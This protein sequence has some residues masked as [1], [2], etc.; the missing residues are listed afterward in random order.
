MARKS[1]KTCYSSKRAQP[2]PTKTVAALLARVEQIG[3]AAAP[4]SAGLD[5]LAKQRAALE[6]LLIE[7]TAAGENVPRSA[8]KLRRAEAQ[9]G[10][11][12]GVLEG[13]IARKPI[14]TL[15]AAIAKL[16][17]YADCQGYD[18]STRARRRPARSFEERLFR[19]VLDD[20]RRMI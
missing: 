18:I 6:N 20:M 1:S 4:A 8:P 17:V 10:K 3:A 14:R 2:S 7:L 16:Q 9:V 13:R 5:A 11:W 19:S 15:G 12:I